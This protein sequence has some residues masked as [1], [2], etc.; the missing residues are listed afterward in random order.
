MAAEPPSKQ[1][2]RARRLAQ[3]LL[4]LLGLGALLLMLERTGWRRIGAVLGSMGPVLWV[5]VVALGAAEQI[6]DSLALRRAMLGRIG[7]AWTVACNGTGALVNAA[8]PFDAGE[9][10]KA[11]LLRKR[12]QDDEVISGLVVWNTVWK[13]S[14]PALALLC[15]LAAITLGHDLPP[16]ITTAVLGGV[17]L[18]FLP[19]VGLR[20]LMR[21]GPAEQGARLLARVPLLRRRAPRLV[22]AAVRLDA[23]VRLFGDQH[24]RA[25]LATFAWQVAARSTSLVTMGLLLSALSLPAR[26]GT[27]AIVYAATVAAHYVT[28]LVPTRLGVVE[29]SA[30]FLFQIFGWDPA[31]GLVVGLAFRIRAIAAQTPCALAALLAPGGKPRADRRSQHGA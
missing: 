1:G 6:F 30:Y 20:L 15:F 2:G 23:D 17:A 13:L 16:R 29:G 25:T 4:P 3:V 18:A 26:P 11:A 28:L 14:Q 10:V 31:A 12:S 5:Q 22:A 8:A 21:V 27:V 7:L 19:F 24:P 9:V